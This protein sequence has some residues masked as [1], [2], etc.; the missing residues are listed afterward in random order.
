MPARTQQT[1]M[2]RWL[3]PLLA[4][5]VAALA[6]ILVGNLSPASAA[7]GAETRVGASAVVAEVLVGPP[8]HITAGQRLGNDVAGPDFVVATVVAANAGRE[9]PLGYYTGTDIWPLATA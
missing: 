9:Q 1:E 2:R 6:A 8:E 7:A 5:L 3:L 4:G